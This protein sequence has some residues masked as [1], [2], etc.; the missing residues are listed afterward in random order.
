MQDARSVL[1]NSSITS[2]VSSNGKSCSCSDL[3]LSRQP[4][5]FSGYVSQWNRVA[6]IYVL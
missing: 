2:G 1:R 5:Y 3:G 6:G 4:Q